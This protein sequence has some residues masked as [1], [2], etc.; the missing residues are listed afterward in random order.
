ME[1]GWFER[2]AVVDR[3]VRRRHA[4]AQ[5]GACGADHR[6]HAQRWWSGLQ[7]PVALPARTGPRNR[8]TVSLAASRSCSASPGTSRA[9]RA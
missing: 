9:T 2:P 4:A 5:V 3:D 1:E 7:L 8:L 6:G